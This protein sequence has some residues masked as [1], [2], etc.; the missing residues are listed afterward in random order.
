MYFLLKMGIFHCY[1]SLTGG[2]LLKPKNKH[3]VQALISP[4]SNRPFS[5]KNVNPKVQGEAVLP[6]ASHVLLMAA[7][8]LESQSYMMYLDDSNC[9]NCEISSWRSDKFRKRKT[10]MY[11]FSICNFSFLCRLQV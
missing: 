11:L 10:I 2:F 5:S 7:A 1:V 8:Y 6:A 4:R 9:K 3:G